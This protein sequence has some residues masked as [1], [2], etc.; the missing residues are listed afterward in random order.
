MSEAISRAAAV[1]DGA[2][3]ILVFT[4]AGISTESA[5]PDFRGPTGLWTTAN[6]DDFTLSNYVSD[7]AFR[8]TAW[9]RRFGSPL[10]HAE[11]NRAH[12]AV[13]DLWDSG[14]MIGCVTQNIDGLHQAAGLP[15]AAIVE[16]HGNRHG[17]RCL[18]CGTEADTAA[19]EALWRGGDA[20][21]GCPVCDG[22]LKSTVVY[23]G[24]MLPPSAL[25][26]A[27]EWTAVADGVI[28]VGSSLSVYP[29]DAIPLEVV[30]TGAALVI[31]NDGP[32]RHDDVATVRLAG[33]AGVVLPQL[34][35]ELT[36]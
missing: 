28:V 11:P 17:I 9:E 5:I 25:E 6:P 30:A 13:V 32:T 3:R 31:V 14:R 10:R 27:A 34:V 26:T 18:N 23:F 4:G 24:E 7:P 1:L 15:G 21:P 2:Y 33:K 8:R 35:A 19:V 12:S 20:D 36:S 22:M 29:A 16:L